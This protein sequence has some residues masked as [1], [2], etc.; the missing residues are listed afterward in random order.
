[1]TLHAQPQARLAR[2]L[3]LDGVAEL[4][5]VVRALLAQGLRSIYNNNNEYIKLPEAMEH[6]FHAAID[7][8]M[9]ASDAELR[10]YR[11]A[12]HRL[13]HGRVDVPRNCN[14]P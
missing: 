1:M 8:K 7:T 14:T 9:V 4:P 5:A 3:A 6:A 10:L 13:G 12:M 2:Q 11:D